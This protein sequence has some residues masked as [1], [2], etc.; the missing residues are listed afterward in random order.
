MKWLIG[1][2]LYPD[3]SYIEAT[4]K[5]FNRTARASFDPLLGQCGRARE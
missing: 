5:F 4:V 1:L 3:R 2:T